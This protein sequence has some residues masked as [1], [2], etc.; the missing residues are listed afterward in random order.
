MKIA[1]LL[2]TAIILLSALALNS[3]N[4]DAPNVSVNST[5]PDIYIEVPETIVEPQIIM[6]VKDGWTE[7]TVLIRMRNKD[8][9]WLVHNISAERYNN[10][11]WIVTVEFQ[12]FSRQYI[13]DE[14]Q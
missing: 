9:P 2:L 7:E 8:Y 6:P 1:V 5:M 4:V 10:R 11:L 14:V 3:P 13:F 12:S